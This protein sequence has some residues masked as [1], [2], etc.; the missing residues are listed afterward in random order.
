MR[1][2]I[3]KQYR[4]AKVEWNAWLARYRENVIYQS[5]DVSDAGQ[6]ARVLC[7]FAHY[8]AQGRIDDYVIHLVQQLA[9][10]GCD[11]VFVSSCGPSFPLDEFDK[12]RSDVKGVIL[13]HN[14]GYDF[15]SW[16]TAIDCCSELV[17]GYEQIMYMND[18][19]Y[20]P[21]SNLKPVLEQ[22][23]E[24]H[25]DIWALTD[26]H[27]RNYHF[28]TYCWGMGGKALHGRFHNW[29]WQRYFRFYSD[30]DAVISRYELKLAQLAGSRFSLLT[31]VVF[32]VNT[33]AVADMS[34]CNPTQ[35]L[36]LELLQHDFPFV[37]RELLETNPRKLPF[38]E[39]VRHFLQDRNSALTAN[40]NA[41]LSSL[42][43]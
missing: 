19:V 14:F 10:A 43:T 34:K 40:V 4:R 5:V 41:H 28:Q 42:N 30:R 24:N 35:D 20:G 11:V 39:E 7:L 22:V 12:I 27:E 16:K 32:P 1:R 25:W 23:L 17:S 15:G 2:K 29:F 31:G 38:V 37:K 36:A 3:R 9:A 6:S 13:R 18:S 8:S 33:F 26:S 21:Y